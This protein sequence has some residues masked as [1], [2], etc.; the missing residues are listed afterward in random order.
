MGVGH[1]PNIQNRLYPTLDSTLQTHPF[2]AQT[3]VRQCPQG[4]NNPNTVVQND[5]TNIVFDSQYFRDVIGGQGLFS[6]D[7]ALATDSRT[8]PIVRQFAMN[9][10]LFFQ[11]FSDAYVKLTQFNVLTGSQG[12]IRKN[13]RNPN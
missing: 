7:A 4:G 11:T 2:F 13:C 3:L 6:I 12:Q 9:Q 1:C 10:Q 8:A 5:L